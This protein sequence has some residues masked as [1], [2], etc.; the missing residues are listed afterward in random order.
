MVWGSLNLPTSVLLLPQGELW[1]A[2][3][4]T[5]V[6][7]TCGLICEELRKPRT[8]IWRLGLMPPSLQSR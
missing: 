5:A 1:G 4:E 2:E 7:E 6:G 3:A 8:G